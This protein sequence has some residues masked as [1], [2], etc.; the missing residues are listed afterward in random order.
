MLVLGLSLGL[1][2]AF[3]WRRYRRPRDASELVPSELASMLV[4]DMRAPLKGILGYVDLLRHE[5]RIDG[6]DLDAL[7]LSAHELDLMLET[8]LEHARSNV[9]RL[10][11]HNAPFAFENVI[12]EALAGLRPTL[13]RKQLDL[14]VG[15]DPELPGLLVGD[16]RRLK[17]LLANLLSNAAKYTPDGAIAVTVAVVARHGRTLTI[18]IE[19]R[20]TGPGFGSAAR[21][22]LFQPFS[23]VEHHALG[24]SGLGLALVKRLVESM[25][26]DIEVDAQREPEPASREQGAAVR[27]RLNLGRGDDLPPAVGLHGR[28]I[29][30]REPH[31]PTRFA[32][33]RMLEAFGAHVSVSDDL[34]PSSG[35]L[36]EPSAFDAIIVSASANE[37]HPEATRVLAIRR[38]GQPAPAGPCIETPVLPG[39]LYRALVDMVSERTA[40]GVWLGRCLIV[41]DDPLSLEHGRS[42]LASSGSNAW[43]AIDGRNALRILR[44]HHIDVV[45]LDLHLPD[46]DAEQ[47]VHE[48]RLR[49]VETVI[50]LSADPDAG[51][52][53]GV[54]FSMAKPLRIAALRVALLEDSPTGNLPDLRDLADSTL[55]KDLRELRD[56][57][58]QSDHE[59]ADAV[60]HRLAGALLTLE[61]HSIAAQLSALRDDLRRA[62]PWQRQFDALDSA[63][64]TYLDDVH[65]R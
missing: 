56:A 64:N 13:R 10:P 61:A 28:R 65:G 40:G 59:R 18:E 2:A 48:A 21:Q 44:E 22:L 37:P 25:T 46:L 55:P 32:I 39:I 27:I 51:A 6:A 20:D 45:F 58:R 8:V 54:D 36:D 30:L 34:S 4:H 31:L 63:V 47:V 24:S 60:C 7:E 57:L 19:V 62:L 52:A 3:L 50:G 16:A 35:S 15:L 5:P 11:V 41:D 49:G 1:S 9:K 42:V 43:T 38:P 14:T 23:A 53:I 33:T 29:A 12:D 17:Q 26:G